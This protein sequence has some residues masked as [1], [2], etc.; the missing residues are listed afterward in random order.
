MV[1]VYTGLGKGKTTAS[2]GL[3]ARAAGHGLK[4]VIVQFMKGS[5]NYGELKSMQK[6][7]VEVRQFGRPDFVN[8]KCPDPV[9]VEFAKD[10]LCEVTKLAHSGVY[11][12]VIADEIN[13]AV[14]FRLI[15]EDEV[16]SLINTKS[17]KTELVL[18][19]RYASDR[20]IQAADLVTEMKE[21][22]HYYNTIGLGAREGVEF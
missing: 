16:L 7:G 9:D 17:K 14:Y 1:Q 19:G 6:L 5:I 11:D 21:I 13:V 22:K 3:A 12:L 8:P 2:L 20:I 10:A 4:V 15:K 18:T